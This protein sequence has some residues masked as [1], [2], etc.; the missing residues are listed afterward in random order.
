M[1]S[2]ACSTSS[3]PRRP[4]SSLNSGL[5]TA[6][7]WK[8]GDLAELLWRS[9][10]PDSASRRRCAAVWRIGY[11][12]RAAP[13]IGYHLTRKSTGPPRASGGPVR[14]CGKEGPWTSNECWRARLA[15]TTRRCPSA[16]HALGRGRSIPTPCSSRASAPAVRP[17]PLYIPQRLV[18]LR[19]RSHESSSYRTAARCVRWAHPRALLARVPAVGGGAPASARRASVVRAPRARSRPGRGRALPAAFRGRGFRLRLLRERPGRGHSRGRV[20]AVFLRHHRGAAGREGSRRGE[21]GS[22][23]PGRGS[24]D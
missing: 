17:R 2:P 13:P 20:S 5:R 14:D 15:T 16:A 8:V 11:D 22:A 1:W 21:Y 18:G 23:F 12:L 24:S 6:S 7:G 3:R 4:A 10:R 9:P 19:F